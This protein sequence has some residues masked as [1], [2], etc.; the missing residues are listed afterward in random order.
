[1]EAERQGD[2]WRSR[3]VWK[4]GL[5]ALLLLVAFSVGQ[6]VMNV[7]ALAQFLWLLVAGEPNRLLQSFGG[8][9]ASW[10]GETARFVTGASEDKPFPWRPWPDAR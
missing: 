10:L 7:V 4:R 8:S 2:A 9:L 6:F 5:F 3:E 1:M